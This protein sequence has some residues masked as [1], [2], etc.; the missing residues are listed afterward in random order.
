MQ[1][2]AERLEDCAI[3]RGHPGGQGMKGPR[4]PGQVL[5]QST[6]L[7]AVPGEDDIRTK[8]EITAEAYLALTTWQCRVH[9]YRHAVARS[10]LDDS[11]EFVARH[12]RSRQL[13]VADTR[14]GEPVQVGS[15]QPDGGNAHQFLTGTRGWHSLAVAPDIPHPV[16]SRNGHLGR[17]T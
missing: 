2:D 17:H 14:L 12:H 3:N 1:C 9:R 16:E 6:V 8:V 10:A 13:R 15:A 11:C 7:A 4:R 5:L